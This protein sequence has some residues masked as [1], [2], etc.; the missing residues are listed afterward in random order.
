[1]RAPWAEATAL[2]GPLRDADLMIVR[3]GA[4][5]EDMVSQGNLIG[6]KAPSMYEDFKERSHGPNATGPS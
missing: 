1:M 5:K 4:D 2:Q 3:R 6:G